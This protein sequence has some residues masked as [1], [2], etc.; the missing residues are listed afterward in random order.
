MEMERDTGT[1]VEDESISVLRMAGR[2]VKRWRERTGLTQAE[3][4]AAIG[5]GDEMVSKVERGIRIPKAEFLDNADRVCKAGG[6]LSELTAEVSQV[7]YPKKLRDLAR[8]EADAVE[9]GAYSSHTVHTLLRTEEYARGLLEMSRPALPP[10]DFDRRMDAQLA[11]TGIF[12]R[13]PTATL[14]FVLEEAT[15]RRPVGGRAALR[16]QLEHLLQLALLRHVEIQVMPTE[17]EDHAGLGGEL[18]V[19]KLSDGTAVGYSETQLTRRLITDPRDIHVL[20]LRY[21]M[22]R[23]QALSPRESVTFIEK[24]LANT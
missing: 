1:D 15:V 9:S 20:E 14:T 16:G 23:A 17:R 8:L 7:R 6:M 4:G 22:L 12:T 13:T 11:R 2:L 21:G 24:A 19:F 3:L 5:Y 18:Q 10:D